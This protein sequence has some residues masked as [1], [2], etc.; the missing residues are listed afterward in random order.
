MTPTE[1][2]KRPEAKVKVEKVEIL[3]PETPRK[4]VSFIGWAKKGKDA[5]CS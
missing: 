5:S 2:N 3:K 4:A 1:K